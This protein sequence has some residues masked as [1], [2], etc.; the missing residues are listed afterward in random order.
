MILSQ[1]TS[2]HNYY[3]FLW[4]ATF[5]AL[6]QNFMDVDTILP[7]MLIEAG[8]N[9]LHVGIMTAIMLGGARL[10]QLLFAPF[11]SNYSFKKKF[12]L[13]GINGRIL[14]L[15]LMALMLWFSNMLRGETM[16]WLIF[17]LIAAFSMGGAF[18]NVS[19]TDILGKS[20][21]PSTRKVFFSIKQ[22][23]TGSV[24]LLSALLAKK[25]LTMK[26]FPGNYAWIF[27]IGFAA[28]LI[29]S[30]GIWNLKERIPSKMPVHNV[31]HFK[32]LLTDELRKNKR[33]G[34]FLGWVNT[35]GISITLLPFVLLY[36]KQVFHTLSQ[37][38]GFYLFYKVVG[39]V[40]IGVLLFL[41]S[42]KFKYRY[43]LYGN[44][45]LALVVPLILLFSDAVPPFRL[46]FLAGGVVFAAYAISM[47]G[48]I[49]EIS[50][51]EN[52]TIYSGIAGAGNILPALFPLLGGWII[53][54][55]GFSPF[56]ILYTF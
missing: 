10:T 28:L 42:R 25:V 50:G 55:F 31:K 27:V 47:N 32:S 6:A 12:L 48:V 26:S 40:S 37:E 13:I 53:E 56:L 43:L 15:L 38:T 17:I 11:I 1:N 16:I 29:A 24:L 21:L 20:V 52:R 22:A 39:T 9:G 34:Y 44:A 14:S 54:H 46:L 3:S 19:Y 51:T 30:L 36:S 18:A 5:L 2:R 23:V 35:M 45:V 33:L 49:L 8:G 41:L 7:A 4:H